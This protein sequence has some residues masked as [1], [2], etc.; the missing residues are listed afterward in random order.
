MPLLF[1]LRMR[2]NLVARRAQSSLTRRQRSGIEN[3]K[4]IWTK[5]SGHRADAC[6][7]E[8]WSN[9]VDHYERFTAALCSAAKDGCNSKVERE[10]SI[11]KRW[12]ARNYRS[13]AAR[14]R[15]YLDVEFDGEGRTETVSGIVDY[16]GGRRN[17]DVLETLV[18]AS[19]LKDLLARDTGDLLPRICRIS[20]AVYR[21]H[22]SFQA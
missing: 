13:V 3:E 4:A 16:I 1:R 8:T 7:P 21:C 11:A 10:F 22:E 18:S 5:A 14:V 6:L 19:S 12:F 15:P 20:E 2:A 17:Q 9:F